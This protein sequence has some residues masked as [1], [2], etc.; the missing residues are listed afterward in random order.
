M[1]VIYSGDGKKRQLE[2]NQINLTTKSNDPKIM[3]IIVLLVL[4]GLPFF[5]VGGYKY[6]TYKNTQMEPVKAKEGMPPPPVYSRRDLETFSDNRQN[7][8][9]GL[10]LGG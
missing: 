8:V 9:M 2:A 6:L 4:L 3:S 10:V 7:Y 5:L 1:R